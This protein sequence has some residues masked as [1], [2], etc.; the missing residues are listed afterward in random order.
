MGSC[1]K[2]DHKVTFP[3]YKVGLHTGQCPDYAGTV[4]F[5]DLTMSD[6]PRIEN[7]GY[8]IG[9][10]VLENVLAPR[11]KSSHK[12]TY[13]QLAIIGGSEGMVGAAL[14]SGRAAL[15]LEAGSVFILFLAT[16]TAKPT[17]EWGQ[18]ELMQWAAMSLV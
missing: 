10:D 18:P 13:G 15:K 9:S 6:H 11:E 8:L 14:L 2:A 3:V 4:Q 5:S 16:N 7:H 1:I 17:I 12:G